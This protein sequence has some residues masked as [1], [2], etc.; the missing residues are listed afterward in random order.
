MQRKVAVYFFKYEGG[1]SVYL[2]IGDDG[3]VRAVI[4]AYIVEI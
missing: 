1:M 3:G 4:N 2:F